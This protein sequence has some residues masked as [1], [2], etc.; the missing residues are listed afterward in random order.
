MEFFQDFGGIGN[1][2][3]RKK[4]MEHT[5]PHADPNRINENAVYKTYA[6]RHNLPLS[7][8]INERIS[9]GYKGKKA[10]RKDAVKFSTHVLSGT[11]EDMKEIFKD[12][13][14]ANEWIKANYAFV[15]KEFG[16]KNG[17]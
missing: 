5:F 1:H 8:A 9:E 14:K 17:Y 16:E 2:I 15:L 6:D 10:I 11:H 12:K 3:D 4:G 7:K 13:E